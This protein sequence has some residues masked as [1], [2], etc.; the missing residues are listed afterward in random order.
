MFK[1]LTGAELIGSPTGGS[2]KMTF[3]VVEFITPNHNIGFN[4]ATREF[5]VIPNSTEMFIRPD[6]EIPFTIEHYKEGI[7]PYLEYVK[8]R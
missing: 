2:T 5:E 1:R 7:D 6:V 3:D 4:V 8:S